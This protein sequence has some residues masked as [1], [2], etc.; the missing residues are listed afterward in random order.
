MYI[1]AIYVLQTDACIAGKVL[2]FLIN[3]RN[4]T[5]NQNAKQKTKC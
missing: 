3:K 1:I 4:D 2:E 5:Q